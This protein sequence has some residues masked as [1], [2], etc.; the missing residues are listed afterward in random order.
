V[1]TRIKPHQQQTEAATRRAE[2]RRLYRR[3]QVF[4]LLI[5]AVAII[6]WR[7]FHT[8]RAWIFPSGWWR[9]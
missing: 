2:Q 6:L 7:L 1:E 4:G 3:N 5:V 9:P 8:N